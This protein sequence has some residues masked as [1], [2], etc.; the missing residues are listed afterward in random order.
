MTVTTGAS[1]VAALA[2]KIEAELAEMAEEDARPFM[3]DLGI[4]EPSRGR[5]VRLTYALL[6]LF[7][8]IGIMIP[9][10]LGTVGIL[11][12]MVHLGLVNTRTALILIYTAQ[13]LPLAIFILSEFM[14]GVSKDLRDMLRAFRPT[15]AQL[16]TKLVLP[17]TVPAMLTSWK[18]NLSLAIRVVTIAPGIFDTPMLA[19]MPDQVRDSLGAQVPFPSR[20]GHP[21]EYAGLVR[22][23]V[24]NRMLNGEVIRLDGAIRMAPR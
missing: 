9:I 1:D 4:A 14:R 20:L 15:R 10:R 13:G 6:G 3:E 11:E 21:E 5:I 2:G 17:A 12:L 16:F 8:A 24:E 22:H 19:A 18:I 7:M 23:I